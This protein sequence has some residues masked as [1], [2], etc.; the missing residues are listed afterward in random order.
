MAKILPFDAGVYRIRNTINQRA[1]YGSTTV[2]HRR[3]I[4]HFTTLRQGT[5]CNVHLQ[6]SFRK[7]GESAFVFE[8]MCHCQPQHVR[9]LEAAFIKA[10][11]DSYNMR[12][13]TEQSYRFSDEVR[14]K[15]SETRRGVPKRKGWHQT[16]KRSKETR[17]KMSAW[18]KGQP[19]S[20]EAVAH[21][22]AAHLSKSHVT[23]EIIAAIQQ[24]PGSTS[25]RGSNRR[26][27]EQYGICDEYVS[28]IRRHAGRFTDEK[29]AQRASVVA[30]G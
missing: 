13:E 12:I 24:I 20:P 21:N 11:P 6:R 16:V 15:M 26:L 3:A 30:N 8:E 17:E 22:S 4:E 18:Q 19:K 29:I 10:N 5:H 27:A 2:L 25:D 28:E 7:Y 23:L 14:Q 1:Y 9:E